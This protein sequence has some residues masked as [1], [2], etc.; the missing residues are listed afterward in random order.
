MSRKVRLLSAISVVALLL[1]S[2]GGG[3]S[4]GRTKNSALCYATQEEKDAAVK[5]AQDAFDA[6]M[7]GGTPGDPLSDTTVPAT[8]DSVV[9]DSPSSTIPMTEPT[10]AADGGGYRR[11]AVR[12]ASSGDT[13]VPP[14]LDGGALTPEQQQA[15]MDLAAA[16]AQP[17]CEGDG[18]VSAEKTCE[19]TLSGPVFGGTSTCEE[20][21]VQIVNS[22]STQAIE[23]Q[24]KVQKLSPLRIR[25]KQLKT[26]PVKNPQL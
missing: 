7:G 12:V 26:L 23:Q 3:D 17:L 16:E 21:V 14:S 9:S 15:Q 1:A 19:I 24:A 25:R 11:P 20:V 5:T 13:T 6:A 8:E 2:C 22:Q 4:S 18:V 10:A